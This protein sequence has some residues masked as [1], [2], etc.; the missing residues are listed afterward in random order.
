M[1]CE[2]CAQSCGA[3]GSAEV[4][5]EDLHAMEKRF[6]YSYSIFFHKED[7]PLFRSLE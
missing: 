5:E 6:I 1:V 3:R 2:V 4:V 7:H